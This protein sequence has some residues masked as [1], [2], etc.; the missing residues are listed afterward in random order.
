MTSL[1]VRQLTTLDF[2]Y[3]CPERGLVGETWLVDVVLS[4]VLNQQGMVFDFGY[5]K[6]QIKAVLDT[7]ADHRLLVPVENKNITVNSD[8]GRISAQLV[9]E[10]IGVVVCKAPEE[11]V[12]LV[13]QPLIN[14]ENLTA[15]LEKKVMEILPDN[16][17]KIEISLYP[18]AITGAFYHYSHGLKKHEGN[19]QRIAHG[20]RSALNVF[21][22]GKD[23]NKL[24]Q[25]WADTWKDIYIASEEDLQATMSYQ[26][27]ICYQLGYQAPQGNFQLLIS[28][29]RCC[30][31]DTD[32]TV[33]LI[34]EHIA[35]V[36]SQKN[37]G[38]RITVQAFEG[39]NKGA[40]A[41]RQESSVGFSS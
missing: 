11:A 37:P 25:Y 23:D 7:L 41:E 8:S 15:F 12:L 39:V 33:E 26:G 34:A 29:D 19:C 35:G 13:N 20:H 38:K 31:F 4:G 40:I 9:T 16:V 1:F 28:A 18:E 24:A 3:L 2:S 6:R 32:T 17:E 10:K 27:I 14:P 36:L 21:V 5:V 22:D 30:L